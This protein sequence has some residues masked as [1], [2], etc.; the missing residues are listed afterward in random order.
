[1]SETVEV[2][3]AGAAVTIRLRLRDE[4]AAIALYDRI[5]RDVADGKPVVVTV[6]VDAGVRDA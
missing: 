5:E 2:D 4:Y 1:M 6:P 3:R